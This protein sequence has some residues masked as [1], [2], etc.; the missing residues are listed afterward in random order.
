MA[1]TFLQGCIKDVC[2]AHPD[3]RVTMA[4]NAGLQDPAIL[5]NGC[6]DA[7]ATRP[8]M[9][10][11]AGV[12]TTT[13]TTTP[14]TTTTT[15]TSTT[16]TSTTTTT[17]TTTTP[18]T[19]TTA[20]TTRT[21]KAATNITTT[22]AAAST[23]Q[24]SPNTTDAGK[25]LPAVTTKAAASDA[26]AVTST[27]S[28]KAETARSHESESERTKR[29][30]PA[31]AAAADAVRH[32]HEREERQHRLTR[33]SRAAAAHSTSFDRDAAR[34]TRRERARRSSDDMGET[35]GGLPGQARA[36]GADA[37]RREREL[38]RAERLDRIPRQSHRSGA[39][40]SDFGGGGDDS[41][42]TTAG[43]G[44]GYPYADGFPGYGGIK[45]ALDMLDVAIGPLTTGLKHLHKAVDGSSRD[46][47]DMEE[48][49]GITGALRLL[50]KAVT[51][52]RL[53]W[54]RMH[55]ATY[56]SARHG[57]GDDSDGADESMTGAVPADAMKAVG[58]ESADA[59][60]ALGACDSTLLRICSLGD[61]ESCSLKGARRVAE[62]YCR[63][64]VCGGSSLLQTDSDD[65]SWLQTQQSSESRELRTHVE[66]ETSESCRTEEQ[67]CRMLCEH[68][69]SWSDDEEEDCKQSCQSDFGKY[70]AV[71][72]KFR[73]GSCCP[74]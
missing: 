33:Q 49:S 43:T 32:H 70:E 72:A 62:V 45:G 20:T 31:R 73:E 22:A 34:A 58:A 44:S 37:T 52:I 11:G 10:F 41:T 59:T 61:A 65:V 9:A 2:S 38:E 39:M 25:P 29:L 5:P 36:S 12:P 69:F 7:T 30:A 21:T 18:T 46:Q 14:T 13:T 23:T 48:K 68:A 63:H 60:Q 55:K 24:A 64:A 35:M 1:D 3:D 16:T 51:P 57:N 67:Y 8:P 28:P 50:D 4:K 66:V 6:C 42:T 56:G 17:I 19:T 54:K 71:L 74:S 26:E 40:T 53:A 27:S 15:T 47:H